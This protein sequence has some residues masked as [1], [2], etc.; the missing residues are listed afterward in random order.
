[1]EAV[2]GRHP[3]VAQ[4]A[5]VARPDPV[6]GEVGVAVVVPANRAHPPVRDDL[7]TFGEEARAGHKL[8]EGLVLVDVLPLTAMQKL[9]RAALRRE[10]D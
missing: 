9:D 5:V 7:R 1:M 10:I 6:M 8:P 3:A 2:L 4:V